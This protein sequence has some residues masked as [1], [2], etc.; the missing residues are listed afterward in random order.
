MSAF[1]LVSESMY[2]SALHSTT[3]EVTETT[4]SCAG[5][6]PESFKAGPLV[7]STRFELMKTSSSSQLS[8]IAT[9]SSVSES[10]STLPTL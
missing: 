9:T 6:G 4:A 7:I 5:N 1:I 10:S 2:E 3:V 8:P